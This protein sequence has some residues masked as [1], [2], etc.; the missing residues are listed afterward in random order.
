MSVKEASAQ[1]KQPEPNTKLVPTFLFPGPKPPHTP[2]QARR[3]L[4]VVACI[5]A[6][7]QVHGVSRSPTYLRRKEDS[8][9][10]KFQETLGTAFLFRRGVGGAGGGGDSHEVTC[11]R[12]Y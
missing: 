11:P 9:M 3:Q 7:L 6:G 10:S 5:P 8:W 2:R 1:R 4:L 12:L